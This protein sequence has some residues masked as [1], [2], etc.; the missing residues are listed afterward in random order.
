MPGVLNY[1][2]FFPHALMHVMW[3][4]HGFA[5]LATFATIVP[6]VGVHLST[7]ARPLPRVIGALL[8]LA[9]VGMATA[10]AI[11][12]HLLIDRYRPDYSETAIAMRKVAHLFDGCAV[13]MT[14]GSLVAQSTFGATAVFGEVTTVPFLEGMMQLGRGQNYRGDFAFVL[15]PEQGTPALKERL[16]TMGKGVRVGDILV[17]RLRL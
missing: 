17:Y 3:S 14:T 1:A 15:L 12:T 2:L 5:G 7:I 16:D 10:G 8:V 6:L 11:Q 13:A 4:M 9:T